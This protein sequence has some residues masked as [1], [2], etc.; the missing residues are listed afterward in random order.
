MEIVQSVIT[1][2]GLALSACANQSAVPC[3]RTI[4]IL[5]P[6]QIKTLD[7]DTLV[8]LPLFGTIIGASSEKKKKKKKTRQYVIFQSIYNDPKKLSD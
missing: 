2:P 4:Q 5:A 7:T 6:S 3:V 1:A 8:D